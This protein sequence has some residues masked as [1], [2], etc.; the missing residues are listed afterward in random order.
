M[1]N[2]ATPLIQRALFHVEY[3]ELELT[4]ANQEVVVD[5]E[6]DVFNKL[7]TIILFILILHIF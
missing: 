2:L 7:K 6:T 5:V 4:I 3:E 1:I